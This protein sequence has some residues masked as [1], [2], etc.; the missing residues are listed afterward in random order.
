MTSTLATLW[1]HSCWRE[2]ARSGA[3]QIELDHLYLGVLGIGGDAARLLGRHGITLRSA[4]EQVVERLLS[5]V[6][7]LSLDAT[8]VV[9]PPRRL[10]EL[11]DPNIPW[12]EPAHELLSSHSKAPD[13]FALLIGLLKE[14]SG[15]IRELVNADGVTPNDLVG[16]LKAGSDEPTSPDRVPLGSSDLAPPARAYRIRRFAPVSP[17]SALGALADPESLSWW[18]FDPNHPCVEAAGT[19]ATFRRGRRDLT[20]SYHLDRSV[21]STV[22]WT[23]IAQGG[24]WDGQPLHVDTFTAT[25][26]PGGCELERVSSRRAFGRVGTALAPLVLHLGA[27]ALPRTTATVAYGVVEATEI[28]EA[29]AS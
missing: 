16:E 29:D 3:R 18:A 12:S 8:T 27:R 24:S 17:E 7:A 25:S 6:G 9:A 19:V 20:L 1:L 14:P 26:A 23:A 11:G 2:A 4:R 28:D 5:E 21:P 13:T 15:R 10:T 22:S